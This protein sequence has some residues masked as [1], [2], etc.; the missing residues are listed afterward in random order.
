MTVVKE[1]GISSGGIA[2]KSRVIAFQY[3]PH[4]GY[5][6]VLVALQVYDVFKNGPLAR[7]YLSPDLLFRQSVD[8]IHQRFMLVLYTG[9]KRRWHLH[10]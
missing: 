2:G 8:H 6:C 7:N 5:E 1:Q 10:N 9:G 4:P 3:L